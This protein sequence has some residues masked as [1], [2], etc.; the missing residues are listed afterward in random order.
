MDQMDL[1]DIFSI[2][3]ISKKGQ[4]LARSYFNRL[5][6]ELWYRVNQERFE[7]HKD[8]PIKGWRFDLS[9]TLINSVLIAARDGFEVAQPRSS[10]GPALDPLTIPFSN[11]EDTSESRQKMLKFAKELFPKLQLHVMFGT[12]SLVEFLDTMKFL[13]SF[14]IPLTRVKIGSPGK[15]DDEL[16]KAVLEQCSDVKN[17]TIRSSSHPHFQYNFR[18]HAPFKF[19]LFE[20]N[21]AEWV[22]KNHLINLFFGCKKVILGGTQYTNQ[23][24]TEIRKKWL[25]APEMQ[26]LQIKIT[27][28]KVIWDL[29]GALPVRQLTVPNYWG[30]KKSEKFSSKQCYKINKADGTPAVVYRR[31]FGGIFFRTDFEDAVIELPDVSNPGLANNF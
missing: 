14:N 21:G 8:L 29:P 23:K 26:Y 22:T 19:D 16:M 12:S 27:A 10:K 4:T 11:P 6:F 9:S 2:F 1:F 15:V 24:L 18:T 3:S 20:L 28:S 17:L 31:L 30:R 7:I 5:K 25:E 13:R